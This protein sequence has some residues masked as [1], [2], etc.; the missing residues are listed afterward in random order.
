MKTDK[1]AYFAFSLLF[2]LYMFDYIDRLVVVSLFPFLRQDWMSF[3]L[4]Q[5]S[6]LK[7]SYPSPQSAAHA[8]E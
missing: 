2:L 4:I 8:A 5:L 3:E 1:N 7:E 6:P